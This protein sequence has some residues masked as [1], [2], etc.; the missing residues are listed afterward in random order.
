MH[1]HPVK[2]T[3]PA[4]LA[5]A[6]PAGPL[7]I[8]ELAMTDLLRTRRVPTQARSRETVQRILG[9]AEAIVSEYGADAA[10]TRA[11][12]ERAGVAAPSL[13]RFFSDRDEILDALLESMLRDLDAHVEEV[14][15]TFAGTTVEEFIRLEIE[16]H[17]AYYE[18]HPGYVKLW[19]GGRIS[20]PVVEIVRARNRLLARRARQVLI[21]AELINPATPEVVFDLLVEFGDGAL[22]MAFRHASHADQEVIETA[23]VALTAFA[24]RWMPPS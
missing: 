8:L 2:A 15:Q 10:T 12:A 11:I 18:Q 14:E 7:A 22:D 23:I 3:L 6:A 21:A 13:Y 16:V 24:E 19:F 20:P 4:K 5:R 17:V 9:A 1:G